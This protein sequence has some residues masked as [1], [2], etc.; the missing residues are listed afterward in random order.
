MGRVARVVVEGLPH[1]VVQR[2]N[3]RQPTFFCEEDY[4]NY[5]ELMSEWCKKQGV[6]R[7]HLVGRDD[8]LANTK[9]LLHPA[10]DCRS[11]LDGK[12][13]AEVTAALRRHESTGRPLGDDSF[14]ARLEKLLSRNLR[15][16]KRGPKANKNENN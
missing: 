16:Q 11:F 12:P 3:R 4:A 2:G 7:A 13:D 5:L 10:P 6:A 8:L 14:V 15:P 9:P 1:H